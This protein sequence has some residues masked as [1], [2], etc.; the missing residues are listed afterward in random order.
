MKN[1]N[2]ISIG[3]KILFMLVASCIFG[4]GVGILFTVF[5]IYLF[6]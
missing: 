5:M 6:N 2:D 4:V 1:S 3:K